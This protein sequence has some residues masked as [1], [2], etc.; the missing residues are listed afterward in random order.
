MEDY[1]VGKKCSGRIINIY[2]GNLIV[3]LEKDVI[4]KVLNGTDKATVNKDSVFD[5]IVRQNNDQG[6]ILD[7]ASDLKQTEVNSDDVINPWNNWNS[8]PVGHGQALTAMQALHNHTYAFSRELSGAR[9]DLADDIAKSQQTYDSF[10]SSVKKQFD[11]EKS[12]LISD[13]EAD[14]NRTEARKNAV[15]TIDK[16]CNNFRD[17]VPGAA[18]TAA[19]SSIVAVKKRENDVIDA[20]NAKINVY[21]E[22]CNIKIADSERVRN[23]K[24]NKARSEQIERD[25]QAERRFEE[26]IK[27][28]IKNLFE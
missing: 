2:Q 15:Y 24:I 22:W 19:T 11:A 10:I 23:E 5:F 4:G 14:I 13:C 16:A 8:I 1:S 28:K 26:R 18:K 3:E 20:I 12:Q 21:K 25:K 17:N 27:N 6:I 7:F 9:K